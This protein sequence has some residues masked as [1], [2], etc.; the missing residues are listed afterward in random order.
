MRARLVCYVVI[1]ARPWLMLAVLL[2]ALSVT[3]AAAAQTEAPPPAASSEEELVDSLE[4]E[5]DAAAESLDTSRCAVACKALES[6]RAAADGI[7]R[8]EPGPR[9]DRARAKVEASRK[10]VLVACPDCEAATDDRSGV[11]PENRP[12]PP[13]PSI[14]PTPHRGGDGDTPAGPSPAPPAEP[15][16]GACAPCAVGAADHGSQAGILVLGLVLALAARR[17]R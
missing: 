16:D 2:A 5:L 1:D 6:M 4:E 3:R 13:P 7:C 14:P 11:K 8:L 17:R 10:K 9:C 15:A 12:A